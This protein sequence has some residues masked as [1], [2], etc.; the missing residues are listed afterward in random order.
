MPRAN[1]IQTTILAAAVVL[2]VVTVGPFAI[3]GA[4]A[5]GS[6]LGHGAENGNYTVDLPFDTDHYPG[7]ENPGGKYNASINHFAASTQ[8]VFEN[9]D[10]PDGLEKMEYIVIGNP[11]VDF[12]ECS[13][14]NTA[15]FGI[16]RDNDDDGTFVDSDLLSYLEKSDFRDNSIVVKFYD[17]DEFGAKSRE[18]KGGKEAGRE[19]GDKNPEL[20]PDDEIVAHQGFRSS[21][22]PCYGMPDEPGWYQ[23]DGKA[24]GTAFSGDFT[25]ID[26]T[27]HYFYICVCDSEKAAYQTLGPPPG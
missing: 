13:T 1:Q 21:A 9:A 17:G 3:P 4:S 16:D 20:Y 19:D 24:N 27:S 10:A 18:D 25:R 7:D 26:L 15:A 5:S 23:I 2:S 8:E 22:G 12:S 11:D 14:S 6:S